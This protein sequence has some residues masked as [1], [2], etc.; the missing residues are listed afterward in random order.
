MNGRNINI[1]LLVL[2]IGIGSMFI[3]HGWSKLEGG[4]AGW[5][6]LGRN[7]QY[8][9]ISFMPAFWGFMA[10]AAEFFG[11]LC[12]ILGF[13]VRP[14]SALILFTMLIAAIGNITRGYGLEGVVEIIELSTALAALFIMGAGQ[15][16]AIR[17]IPQRS[18]VS[19]D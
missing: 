14:A 15:F 18:D 16:T 13:G 5:E 7:M 17:L 9:G 11:G 6:H 1:G 3:L 4:P 10:M 12:L 19:S 8:V 2:R